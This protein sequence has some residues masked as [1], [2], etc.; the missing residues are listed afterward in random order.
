[1][2]PTLPTRGVIHRRAT[3]KAGLLQWRALHQLG[4]ER[5]RADDDL[6][7]ACPTAMASLAPICD[8]L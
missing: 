2:C 7:M 6:T 5:R 4:P 1:M 3:P 8:V